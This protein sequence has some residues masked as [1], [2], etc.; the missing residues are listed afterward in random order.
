VKTVTACQKTSSVNVVSIWKYLP[1]WE[2]VQLSEK[3]QTRA[4]FVDENLKE[5]MQ[6]AEN[7]LN[8]D[9]FVEES[10]YLRAYLFAKVS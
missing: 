2:T 10:Y 4:C 6:I 3:R 1:L 9:D 5:R 7:R 8:V